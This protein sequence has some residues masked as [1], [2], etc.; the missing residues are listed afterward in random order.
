MKVHFEPCKVTV[1]G[2]LAAQKFMKLGG[3]NSIT[4]YKV[5]D[6][7]SLATDK[8]FEQ[9]STLT[10]STHWELSF[11]TKG[12]LICKVREVPVVRNSYQKTCAFY[13]VLQFPPPSSTLF[14][15]SC[16]PTMSNNNHH[17][18]DDS[19]TVQPYVQRW[20]K[21]SNIKLSF[22][23]Q[24]TMSA[25]ESAVKATTFLDVIQKSFQQDIKIYDN[26]DNELRDY[27]LPDADGQIIGQY[28][29]LCSKQARDN[30]RHAIFIAW[31]IPCP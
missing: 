7:I 19:D 31:K 21:T 12:V 18:S 23:L 8:P 9:R 6:V 28:N 13:K 11:G 25:C 26:H 3:W 24:E 30:I 15:S 17:D 5:H 2:V 14:Y 29:I 20:W 16:T 1:Q 27:T 4:Y 22:H 10:V